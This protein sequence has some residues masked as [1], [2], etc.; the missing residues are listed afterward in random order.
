[1]QKDKSLSA[2]EQ[3]VNPY[4][5]AAKEHEPEQGDIYADKSPSF[6]GSDVFRLV[7]KN[8]RGLWICEDLF[9][10][11]ELH[12]VSSD[13][14][15][16]YYT[17][18][19][20]GGDE[21][22]MVH[23]AQMLTEGRGEEVARIVTGELD[24]APADTEALM[25]TES[26]EH[27]AALLDTSERLQNKLEEVRLIAKCMFETRK[28]DMETMLRSMDTQLAT[29]KEKVRNLI[30]VITVLNLYTG[31]TVELNQITDGEPAP[32]QEPLSLRQRILFMDEELCVHLDH[33]ADYRDI[34]TFFEW[35][36]EPENRDIIVPE[37]RCVVCLKPKRFDM[38]YRSGDPQ[39]DKIRN[40]WNRH[41]YVVIRNGEKL[42]WLESED[43]EVFDWAFPH[44]DINEKFA[45]RIQK[46]EHSREWV[47]KESDSISY[48]VTKYMMFLQG[49]IDQRQEILG[50]LPVRPNLLKLQGVRL[51]R[52]D[53]N[54]IGTGIKPWEQ[55]CR[56]KN[57]LI[58]RGT[59]I[60]YTG[61]RK[62]RDGMGTG[63]YRWNSGGEFIKYYRSE[64]SE[65]EPPGIGIY[66]ADTIKTVVRYMNGKPVTQTMDRLV[67]RYN[68]E[69]T[70]FDRS[71]WDW[72][73]H[74]RKNRIAWKYEPTHVL[75]Y[76]DVSAEELRAYLEDRT[77]RKEFANMI[78][79]LKH[80]LDFKRKEQRDENAF[81][82]LMTAT[83]LSETGKTVTDSE[84][85]AAIAWWKEKVIYTRPL[86]SDD[87]KAF[88]MIRQRLSHR[89]Q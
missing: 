88:R 7:K 13:T 67:F 42:Y 8:E 70:V 54:L 60:L 15:K 51:V 49:I 31:N 36:K 35:L 82:E 46:N 66:H 14:L 20:N 1:M 45:E 21:Y 52:D 85:D 26:P 29:I 87:A 55:F 78:P 69:D 30:K 4:V 84:L 53:E 3:H 74:T 24:D 32:P 75:N 41:T 11:E 71:T 39:Y 17:W 81:K 63:S 56:E 72:E 58:R 48:R 89:R 6:N 65:P 50:P 68:P 47:Q 59:R 80:M 38:D 23:L 33:E 10:G 62:L 27:I 76:D 79:T 61:G 37:Q 64:Y 25:A 18:I 43:L 86:R 40:Q 2:I 22:E 5:R 28:R 12:S 83:I 16:E 44:D 19:Q 9:T 73:G 77:L 34:P 57:A